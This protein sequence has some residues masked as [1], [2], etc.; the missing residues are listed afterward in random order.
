MSFQPDDLTRTTTILFFTRWI[1]HIC[2]PVFM[3]TA[4]MGAFFWMRGGRTVSELSQFLWKRGLWLVFLELTVLRLIMTFSLT[5]GFV[6]LSILWAL[7]WSMVALGFLV[8]LPVRFLAVLSI[9]MIALHN[10]ADPIAASRFGAAAWIWN[11]LHQPGVFRMGGV[12]SWP[13]TRSFRGLG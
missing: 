12:A 7:G 8:R 4:G 10:L 1:T 13:G 5:E 2:A 3:F 11:V 6:L 9:A